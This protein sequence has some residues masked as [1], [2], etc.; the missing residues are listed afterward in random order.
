MGW[1]KEMIVE[2]L[3]VLEDIRGIGFQRPVFSWILVEGFIY[4]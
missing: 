2:D 3:W 1:R 4:L